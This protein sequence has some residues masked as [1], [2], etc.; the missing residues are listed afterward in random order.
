MRW[1]LF[2]QKPSFQTI[3]LMLLCMFAAGCG[4][5]APGAGGPD[6]AGDSAPRTSPLVESF[7]LPLPSKLLVLHTNDN[8]GETEPCG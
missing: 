7:P 1:T 2:Y 6:A 3:A 8:W 4:P 5:A